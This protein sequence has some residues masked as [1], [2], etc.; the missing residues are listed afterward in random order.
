M[1]RV[2]LTRYFVVFDPSRLPEAHSSPSPVLVDELD[3]HEPRNPVSC[4]YSLLTGE[5]YKSKSAR[6]ACFIR[7]YHVANFVANS[8]SPMPVASYIHGMARAKHGSY[9]FQR[10]GSENWWVKLRSPTGRVEKSLH[11][12]DRREAEIAALPLIRDH[13]A[14]LL[15]A[16]PRFET[17]WWYE[18]EPGREHVGSEGQRIIA[19]NQALIFLDANGAIL[20]TTPNGGLQYRH[21]TRLKE[22]SF[23]L[24]DRERA[25]APP[26]K[27]GD[28]EIL[29]TYLNHRN[30]EGYARSEA[31]TVWRTFKELT[32]N[33]A[34]KDCTR[35]DG[36]LLAQH[37]KDAGNKSATVV[38][39][40]SWLR[41][42]VRLAIKEGRLQ[43]NPFAE[44]VAEDDDKLKRK[45]LSDADMKVCKKNLGT[46]GESDQLLFRF[47]ATTG[48][49]LGEAFQINGEA[50]ELGVR[51]VVIGSKTEA[52]Q[53]RVPL[54]ADML[55]HLPKKIVGPLF[56]GDTS[57]A[58]TRLNR[59][60]DDECGLTDPSIVL[61]SLRHRAADRLRAYECPIDIRRA[62]LGHEDR[63]V[64][65]GYGEG[66]SV[67]LLRKWIDCISF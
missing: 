12:V 27:N 64:S 50:T 30:I 22:P 46:L 13:K 67:K 28:D 39:K 2:M 51:Y 25:A 37:F 8:L 56:T 24:F 20:R 5:H 36:R 1:P 16:R 42:A 19:T 35:D 65:E 62:I 23:E 45:P 63:S 44:V 14:A 4:L 21:P 11:T 59:F 34:L 54:P 49:R 26:K 43:F 6:G 40:V 55:A 33:K 52:S 38:K 61:H 18:Y 60:L 15:A 9:I 32:S 17:G 66:F 7:V 31:E 29:D 58:S 3:A 10:P 57:A 48:A 53:R 41:A 47:L